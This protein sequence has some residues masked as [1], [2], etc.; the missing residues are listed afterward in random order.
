MLAS[1]LQG[2]PLVWLALPLCFSLVCPSPSQLALSFSLFLSVSVM[3]PRKA[4]FRVWKSERCSETADLS[5]GVI[6][7]CEADMATK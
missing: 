4:E 7:Y 5:Q 6:S 1:L 2:A 3:S